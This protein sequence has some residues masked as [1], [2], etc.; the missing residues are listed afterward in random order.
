[1]DE[2]TATAIERSSLFF[3]AT[4]MAVTCSAVRGRGGRSQSGDGQKRTGRG[5]GAGEEKRERK[6]TRIA[7]NGKQNERNELA[8]DVTSLR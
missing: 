8:T 4:V 3:V 6:R 5:G 2:P 7:Y 1:M